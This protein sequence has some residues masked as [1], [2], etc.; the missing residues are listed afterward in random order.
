MFYY[1]R[2]R[3]N[4]MEQFSL[5]TEIIIGGADLKELLKDIQRV[6]IVTDGFMAESGMSRNNWKTPE[7][8]MGYSPKCARTRILPR[9]QREWSRWRRWSLRL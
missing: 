9:W 2:K 3:G 7:L 1:E 8:R 6:F 4:G 5:K